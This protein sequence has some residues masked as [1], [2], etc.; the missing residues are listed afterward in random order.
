MPDMNTLEIIHLY[1]NPLKIADFF[2]TATL[3]FLVIYSIFYTVKFFVK[4]DEDNDD[5]I[6]SSLGVLFL[7][8]MVFL[9]FFFGFTA[10]YADICVK[11]V[12][13]LDIR[14]FDMNH[15]RD[16]IKKG[17][18]YYFVKT[19]EISSFDE[20]CLDQDKEGLSNII[21]W[22][23]ENSVSGTKEKDK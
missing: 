11:V 4:K 7:S 16:F 9:Y 14:E 23:I 19:I 18:D 6:D 17:D 8:S 13:N 22:N 21:K 15:S 2:I 1:E 5:S 20:F 10:P 3:V 12:P